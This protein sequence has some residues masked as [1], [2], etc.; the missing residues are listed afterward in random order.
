MSD[1]RQKDLAHVE[2]RILSLGQQ[3]RE[4]QENYQRY[5]SEVHLAIREILEKAG[6]LEE[7]NGMEVERVAAGKKADEKIK[8]LT[9]Q[10]ADLQKVRA[11]LLGR[12]AAEPAADGEPDENPPEAEED[13]EVEDASE[14][15]KITEDAE[16][17]GEEVVSKRPVPPSF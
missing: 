8:A 6:V 10:A 15:P 3:A 9:A 13:P 1:S 16:D 14:E 4:I 5:H 7:V 12:E 2:E 17:E 11:F